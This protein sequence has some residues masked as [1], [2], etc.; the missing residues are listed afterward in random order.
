MFSK[1]PNRKISVAGNG[2]PKRISSSNF[3]QAKRNSKKLLA[4]GFSNKTNLTAARFSVKPKHPVRLP[5]SVVFVT[6][7][8]A[9]ETIVLNSPL[10]PKAEAA[11]K[12]FFAHKQ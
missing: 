11:R 7:D 1:A 10:S 12:M 2:V 4:E 5:Q 9:L 3:V 8:P 6:I